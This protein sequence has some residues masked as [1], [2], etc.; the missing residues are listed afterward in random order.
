MSGNARPSTRVVGSLR[1]ADGAGFVRIE[2]RYDTDIEDLWD[3]ITD[4][5]RL[6]RWHGQV[7]GDLRPGERSACTSRRTTSRAPRPSLPGARVGDR[8]TDAG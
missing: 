7:E 8:V 4:P 2:D 1:S 3:A 5:A 6:A